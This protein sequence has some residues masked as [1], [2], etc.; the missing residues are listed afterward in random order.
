MLK[1]FYFT[2]TRTPKPPASALPTQKQ[3]KNNAKCVVFH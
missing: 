3:K 1:L 2:D